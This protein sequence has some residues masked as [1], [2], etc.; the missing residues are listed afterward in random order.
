MDKP[1]KTACICLITIASALAVSTGA[2]WSAE[3]PRPKLCSP[4]VA[5]DCYVGYIT[6]TGTLLVLLSSKENDPLVSLDVQVSSESPDA[7]FSPV[8]FS[9]QIGNIVMLDAVGAD[10]IYSARIVSVAD[11][12]FTALYMATIL[13][14]P[15]G[16][17]Q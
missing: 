15:P 6:P 9:K 3:I 1:Y 16:E 17:Q 5:K 12:I 13:K 7:P 10:R 14:V 8:D 11:P 2:S 4:L